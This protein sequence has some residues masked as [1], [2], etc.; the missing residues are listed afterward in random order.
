MLHLLDVLLPPLNLGDLAHYLLL[1]LHMYALDYLLPVLLDLLIYQ[2]LLRPHL[3]LLE[4]VLPHLLLM[5]LL[6]QIEYDM[7]L[8]LN[9]QRLLFDLLDPLHLPLLLVKL[10]LQAC[11]EHHDL[12]VLLQDLLFSLHFQLLAML[13][14]V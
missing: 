14:L 11:L 7:L 10:G 12:L 1:I 9:L 6:L 3:L 5:Q 2:L 4:L 13:L 8:L